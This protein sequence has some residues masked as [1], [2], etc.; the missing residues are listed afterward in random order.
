MVAGVST[1]PRSATSVVAVPVEP[2]TLPPPSAPSAESAFDAAALRG[3][4]SLKEVLGALGAAGKPAG[5]DAERYV[6]E[7]LRLRGDC[8]L[9]ERVT[10][11]PERVIRTAL[12]LG[13]VTVDDATA[14]V[15]IDK[16]RVDRARS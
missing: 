8:A 13:L 1:T 3:M 10:N 9:L 5:W 6:Q 2:S 16:Y 4:G 15:L 11:L 12:I 14:E 7:C